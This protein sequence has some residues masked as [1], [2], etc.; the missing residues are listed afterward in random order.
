MSQTVPSYISVEQEQLNKKMGVGDCSGVVEFISC[1]RHSRPPVHS[2]SARSLPALNPFPHGSTQR[3]F[4]FVFPSNPSSNTPALGRLRT[5][6]TV[7]W[8]TDPNTFQ[9]QQT[10]HFARVFVRAQTPILRISFA[11]R[12]CA[13]SQGPFLFK[14][15]RLDNVLL[16]FRYYGKHRPFCGH[17]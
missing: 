7:G 2:R 15:T 17:S 11:W 5:K 10:R 4:R 13:P 8:V 1:P 3:G 12:S 16:L 6:P 14:T 9:Q